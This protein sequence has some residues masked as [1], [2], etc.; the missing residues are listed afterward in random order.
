MYYFGLKLHTLAFRRE[1]TMPFPE[2]IILSSTEENDL[3]VLKREAADHIDNRN[4]FADKI[5][6]DLPFWEEEQ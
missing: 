1:R 5:Y 6:F 4:I 3:I 2:M